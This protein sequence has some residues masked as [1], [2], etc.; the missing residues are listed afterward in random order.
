MILFRM[1]DGHS[2][3]YLHH[4]QTRSRG[5]PGLRGVRRPTHA[6]SWYEALM[7]LEKENREMELLHH[8]RMMIMYI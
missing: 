6:G 8:I 4:F 7:K 3:G 5:R 2:D 1:K